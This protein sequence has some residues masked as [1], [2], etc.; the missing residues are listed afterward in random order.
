M[1]TDLYDMTDIFEEDFLLDSSEVVEV[2]GGTNP[3]WVE[4]WDEEFDSFS[5]LNENTQY[6]IT[7]AAH[8]EAIAR[9]GGEA[10]Q[11]VDSTDAGNNLKIGELSLSEPDN[12]FGDELFEMGTSGAAR[13]GSATTG[14]DGYDYSGDQDNYIQTSYNEIMAAEDMDSSVSF[15]VSNSHDDHSQAFTSCCGTDHGHDS[16]DPHIDTAVSEANGPEGF[17]LSCDC[18]SCGGGASEGLE[19]EGGQSSEDVVD[20]ADEGSD[21]SHEGG[22]QY[23][24]VEVESGEGSGTGADAPAATASQMTN[25]LTQG[26]WGGVEVSWA[27]TNITFSLSNFSTANANGL[28][29]A[30]E[31]WEDVAGLNFTEVGS[32]GEISLS[33]G[34][35]GRAYSSF[36]NY[37]WNGAEGKYDVYGTIISIDTSIYG[38]HDLN[39]IGEYGL[40]TGVHEIAHS[41]GLGHAGDYNGSATYDTDAQYSNDTRQYTVMSYFSA[42]NSGADYLDSSYDWKYASTPMLFDIHAMQSLYGANYST[43]SG[44]TTYGFNS[45][46]G[47]SQFDFSVTVAPVATIWDGGGNDTLDLSG[48]SMS[49]TVRL[50]SGEFSN[51]GGLINNLTIAYGATVENAIGGSAT[52][53]LYGN[54]A[55]NILRGGGGN[56]QLYGGEGDDI[57]IGDAGSDLLF[58]GGGNDTAEFSS[59]LEN[60]T[61]YLSGSDIVIVE[62]MSVVA[63]ANSIESF[64]FDG[65]T[66]SAADV[67]SYFTNEG[68]ELTVNDLTLTDGQIVLASSVISA[69]DTNDDALTYIIR[70]TDGGANSA[71]ILLDGVALAADTDHS[72][73]QAEFDRLEFVGGSHTGLEQ[74]Q[75][76]VTDGEVTTAAQNVGVQTNNAGPVLTISSNALVADY[77]ESLLVSEIVSISD[78]TPDSLSITICD[79]GLGGG[80]FEIDGEAVEA[81]TYVT[82]TADEFA[83]LR[84]VGGSSGAEDSMWINVSDGEHSTGFDRFYLVTKD[85][86]ILPQ[87]EV[88]GNVILAGGATALVSDYFDVSDADGDTL[89]YEI[90]DMKSGNYGHMELDGQ[91][92][93]ALSYHSLTQAEFERLE[94]VGGTG[95]GRSDFTLR[96]HD[97]YGYSVK[98]T[99]SLISQNPNE[100]PT[101]T[102]DG[103][104]RVAVDDTILASSVI[105]SSDADGDEISYT[106]WDRTGG[107]SSGYFELDGE[108]LD[109]NEFH[110]LTA[111]EFATLNIVAG[112]EVGFDSFWVMATDGRETTDWQRFVLESHNTG[113]DVE[114]SGTTLG[115]GET[116]LASSLIDVSDAEGDTLSY[117]IYDM[118]GSTTAYLDL[119]GTRL[120]N[121]V[122][123]RLTQAEFDRL[124]IVGGS[125]AVDN[126][127][128]VKVSD[129]YGYSDGYEFVVSSSVDVSTNVAPTVEIKHMATTSG[130][131]F[132]V[133]DVLTVDDAN[134][135]TLSYLV[136]DTKADGDS[137]YFSL[138][139]F[140]LSAGSH[141][142]LTQAEFDRLEVVANTGGLDQLRVMVSDGELNAGWSAFNVRTME[143]SSNV[144]G[145][146][147][148]DILRGDDQ[149]NVIGAG[150]GDD[151]IYGDAGADSLIGREGAD[152]F[153]FEDVV[154]FDA[155]DTIRDFSV[156]EGDMLDISDILSGFYDEGSDVLTDFVQITDDGTHTTVSVDQ[157]GGG[158]NF[159]A[160]ASLRN[161]TG[162]TDEDQLVSDGNLIV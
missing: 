114:V 48:Y 95:S 71:Y 69:E 130:S 116:I 55:N 100:A 47:R 136:W 108:A 17:G 84:V 33:R 131:S 160:V 72:F 53:Y 4:D 1:A 70:D 20:S 50:T 104:V 133:S 79:M 58:G 159:V 8:V 86:N 129:G 63:T 115:N 146:S 147:S 73:T 26:Y 91:E 57:L 16:Q 123:H 29:A 134:D 127:F 43:R 155:V 14:R 52:D 102:V 27:D 13:Y 117:I 5:E 12:G 109:A 94:F 107:A 6:H 120:L 24:I 83:E 111:A 78:G 30:F 74:F 105:S 39:T 139:G 40:Q 42:S 162:L 121:S 119:D 88:S 77:S 99:L 60:Y 118:R 158:D 125:K 89:T 9:N 62:G 138:D 153:V 44:D 92:L 76:R 49:Q 19:G 23:I 61:G 110:Q 37:S 124:E 21:Y 51:I 66:Y 2:D 141:H 128:I 10:E 41:L 90:M 75:V 96:V 38:W 142:S 151:V 112:S 113:P 18:S 152:R 97:G 22:G 67:I 36:Q 144:A 157:N 7:T 132:L 3:G 122:A 54:S 82:L 106:I 98:S 59:S 32:G 140:E 80:Y 148:D 103:V 46:A 87:I 35:D 93:S 56:D 156:A 65:V 34:S 81:R 31:L 126:S 68:P 25:W 161:V 101:V 11:S 150:R 85:L 154:A 143:G 145:F 45:N 64:V 135:D 149:D 15:V 137:S 28:R